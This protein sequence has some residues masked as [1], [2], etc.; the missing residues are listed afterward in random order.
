MWPFLQRLGNFNTAQLSPPAR[1]YTGPARLD[2]EPVPSWSELALS[3]FSPQTLR[4]LQLRFQ[5]GCDDA[6]VNLRPRFLA[7]QIA[8]LAHD[9]CKRDDLSYPP[10]FFYLDAISLINLPVGDSGNTSDMYVLQEQY[11]DVLRY[12]I[13]NQLALWDRLTNGVSFAILLN[14]SPLLRQRGTLHKEAAGALEQAVFVT[15]RFVD[16]GSHD[17]HIPLRC[18]VDSVSFAFG[19]KVQLAYSTA[20]QNLAAGE[21]AKTW[22]P[23]GACTFMPLSVRQSNY[24]PIPPTHLGMRWQLTYLKDLTTF[25]PPLDGEDLDAP[26]RVRDRRALELERLTRENSSMRAEVQKLRRLGIPR[27]YHSVDDL[28]VQ[29]DHLT[30]EVHQ[31]QLANEQ[32]TALL[33]RAHRELKASQDTGLP[34]VRYTSVR[35]DVA[36]ALANQPSADPPPVPREVY[37]AAVAARK[38]LEGKVV[39][40]QAMLAHEKELSAQHR[41]QIKEQAQSIQAF[42]EFAACHPI[43]PDARQPRLLHQLPN[44]HASEWASIVGSRTFSFIQGFNLHQ[45][46]PVIHSVVRYTSPSNW[47][48]FLA[49]RIPSLDAH[50]VTRLLLTV[51]MDLLGGSLPTLR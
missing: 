4:D 39:Y 36:T 7:A 26:T 21:S 43:D 27:V 8:W 22:A 32:L 41:K 44:V 40:L 3:S 46:L 45:L 48:E 31:L 50:V 47:C 1:L 18:A 34:T 15:P 13:Q 49:A 19:S 29:C 11:L 9:L 24:Y 28:S 14:A 10:E 35:T 16:D 42:L 38:E 12:S 37:D 17:H 25:P 30:D 2:G 23:G 51:G 33:E 20:L 5:Q 6:P